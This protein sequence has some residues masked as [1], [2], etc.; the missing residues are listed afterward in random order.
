LAQDLADAVVIA[1]AEGTIA[2]WNDAAVRLFGWSSAEAVGRS[3][4]VIIPERLRQR[5]WDGYTQVMMSGHSDYG[6]RLLEVPALHRDGHRISLAFTV[7]LLTRPG[8]KEPFAIAAVLR[9]DTERFQER[10][11]LKERLAALEASS[12]PES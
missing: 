5:H 12:A 3:L 10:R 8:Q 4:D 2:F 1:D 9:D 6:T 11:V 7:T